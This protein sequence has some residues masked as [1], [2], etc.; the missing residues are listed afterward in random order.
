M[1][2]LAGNIMKGS[3]KYEPLALQLRNGLAVALCFNS[4]L[5]AAMLLCFLT[6]RPLY[7]A[8]GVAGLFIGAAGGS[9]INHLHYRL[10][11]RI[12]VLG[13]SNHCPHCLKV[14]KSLYNM[15]VVGWLAVR[16]RCTAC[17]SQIPV[18][19]FLAEVAGGLVSA[20][21]WILLAGF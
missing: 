13:P 6:S 12:P 14:V 18:R 7:Y 9:F 5:L 3:M 10:S 20:L 2:L 8:G 17:K 1:L 4:I 15:P 21:A 19:Y 11:R 16:G